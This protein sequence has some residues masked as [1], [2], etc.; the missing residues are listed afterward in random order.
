MKTII[1]ITICL[2]G[3]T[4]AAKTEKRICTNI[5]KFVRLSFSTFKKT[6]DITYDEFEKSIVG[7]EAK[8]YYLPQNV[9]S[10]IAGM[11]AHGK[12]TYQGYKKATAGKLRLKRQDY[13]RNQLITKYDKKFE[14]EISDQVASCILN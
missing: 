12:S 4:A 2:L 8:A 11:Y 3:L 13:N 14:S 1:M 6:P 10:V 9:D 7:V 5:A